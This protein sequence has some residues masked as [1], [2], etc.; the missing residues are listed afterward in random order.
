MRIGVYPGSFN[1]PHMGHFIIA[2]TLVKDGLLDKVIF[3]PTSDYYAKEGLVPAI[4]RY[5]MLKL[6][7]DKYNYLEVSDLEVNKN[8]QNYTYQTLDSIQMIYPNDEIYLVIGS[9]NLKYLNTWKHYAYIM[10]HYKI[11]SI[12]RDYKEYDIDMLDKVQIV[13]LYLEDISS[14]I[15]RDRIKNNQDVSDLLPEEVIKYI[16]ENNL[17]KQN[18]IKKD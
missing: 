15:V 18:Q 12:E 11:I 3:V 7:A 14:T 9:D 17:Y 16:D 5:E 1:P 13:Q 4:N 6:V 10:D 8:T 2:N